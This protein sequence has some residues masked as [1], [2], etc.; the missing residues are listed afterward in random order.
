MNPFTVIFRNSHPEMFCRKSVQKRFGKFTEKHPSQIAISVK[1]QA[2]LQGV[3]LQMVF[4]WLFQKCSEQLTCR[5]PTDTYLPTRIFLT[6]T[7]F[8]LH[9]IALFSI[10]KCTSDRPFIHT[11][12]KYLRTLLISDSSWDV[13]FWVVCD[14]MILFNL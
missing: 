3:F 6:Q 13:L 9:C 7:M 8:R 12:N 11:D 4:L 5:T 1:L 2:K 14:N 10:T